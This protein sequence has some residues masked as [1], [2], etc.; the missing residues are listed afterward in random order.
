MKDN[1]ALIIAQR[2]AGLVA[3]L[4]WQFVAGTDRRSQIKDIRRQASEQDVRSC[5]LLGRELHAYAGLYAF[6]AGVS[7]EKRPARVYSFAALL[8]HRL[9]AADA[10]VAWRIQQGPHQGMYAVV[11]TQDHLPVADLVLG[12]A[13]AR[14]AVA[15][16]RKTLDGA[17]NANFWSNDLDEFP[18]A[19]PMVLDWA[20]IKPG[21]QERIRAI[22]SDPLS[23]ASSL[24]VAA[25]LVSG[26]LAAGEYSD[27]R[28]RLMSDHS[29]AQLQSAQAYERALQSARQELGATGAMVGRLLETWMNE[30]AVLANWSLQD[31]TCD[32]QHCVQQWQSEGGYTGELITAMAGK[33]SIP[34]EHETVTDLNA[35]QRLKVNTRWHLHPQG[36]AALD[37]LPD[38]KFLQQL[39]FDESQVWSKARINHRI[40]LQGTV[41]PAGFNP[42]A[43]QTTLR[44]HEVVI[45]A[46]AHIINHML[47]DYAGLAWWNRMQLQV[48]PFDP[49]NAL[50]VELKGAFYSQH[51]F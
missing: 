51:I 5:V 15:R 40:D 39:L 32:M 44:R 34:P 27:Y 21:K 19:Q 14:S 3:G 6:D 16:F 25:L 7:A 13:Q 4:Q 9:H 29:A 23:A 45:T 36:V 17:V 42:V 43:Q 22:P 11:A 48:K 37:D 24:T 28:Q 12:Q 38:E 10:V 47:Q 33:N 35:A 30:P 26:L 18:D 41:W 50:L 1:S 46:P 2:R 31:V 8:S 20:E 49:N